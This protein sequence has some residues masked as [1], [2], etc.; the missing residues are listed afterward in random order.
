MAAIAGALEL[1]G[2]L[3]KED[4]RLLLA[5]HMPKGSIAEPQD[6]AA[7]GRAATVDNPS[8][9]TA[10]LETATPPGASPEGHR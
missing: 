5:K 3:G 7:Q 8:D 4:I 2:Y 9:A 1:R 6:P 10:L